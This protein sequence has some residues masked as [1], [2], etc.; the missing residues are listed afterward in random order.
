MVYLS[1]GKMYF[2]C[3]CFYL[4][5]LFLKRDV[6]THDAAK[7]ME[8]YPDAGFALIKTGLTDML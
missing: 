6:S 2:E 4:S 1:T 3:F 7:M 5:V 8:Q